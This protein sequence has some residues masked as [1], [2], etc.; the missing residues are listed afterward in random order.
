MRSPSVEFRTGAIVPD[1]SREE[2][3]PSMGRDAL[4]VHIGR[5]SATGDIARRKTYGN[6]RIP[7]NLRPPGTNRT[8]GRVMD[9]IGYRII[10]LNYNSQ[11]RHQM[12]CYTA[13]TKTYELVMEWS[14]LDLQIDDKIRMDYNKGLVIWFCPRT[15]PMVLNLERGIRTEAGGT[16]DV[17]PR[18][19]EYWVFDQLHRPPAFSPVILPNPTDATSTSNT[20]V[21]GYVAGTVPKPIDNVTETGVQVCFNYEYMDGV[22]SRYSEPSVMFWNN[23]VYV[24]VPQSEFDDYMRI[25]TAANPYIVATKWY[26]REGNTQ[27]WNLFKRVLNTPSEWIAPVNYG[28]QIAGILLTDLS[29]LTPIGSVSAAAALGVDGS[30]RF[31]RTG[32]FFNNRILQGG[33]TLGYDVDL[34]GGEASFMILTETNMTVRNWRIFAPIFAQQHDFMFVYYDDRGRTIGTRTINSMSFRNLFFSG[35]S[36]DLFDVYVA[37]G[38]GSFAI[39]DLLWNQVVDYFNFLDPNVQA[40]SRRDINFPPTIEITP[41]ATDLSTQVASV[42][43]ATKSHRDYSFFIRTQIRPFFIYRDASGNFYVFLDN[44]GGEQV[45]RSSIKMSFYGIGFE[46]ASGEPINF[47]TEQNYYVKQVGR[48]FARATTGFNYQAS[49]AF[50]VEFKITDQLGNILISKQ[51]FTS[52]GNQYYN[53]GFWSGVDV[54]NQVPNLGQYLHQICDV[55]LYSKNKVKSSD[56]NIIPQITWTPVEWNAR[57]VKRYYGDCYGCGDDKTM[58]G[59][60][61]QV[62]GNRFNGLYTQIGQVSWQGFWASMNLNGIFNENWNSD[63]GSATAINDQPQLLLQSRTYQHGEQYLEGTKINNLF[64]FNVDNRKLVDGTIGNI[65]DIINQSISANLGENL[66]IHCEQGVE[67]VMIGKVQQTGTDGIGILA[68]STKVFGTTNT[69]NLPY[70][71]Q[72]I[73]QVIIT[74]KGV[75]YYI[76]PVNR[77]LVQVSRNG[78]DAVSEQKDFISHMDNVPDDAVIGFDPLRMEILVSG[79]GYG[80][81]YKIDDNGIYQGRRTYGINNQT[82]MFAFLSSPAGAKKTYAFFDGEL[83]E[84]D[85]NST[86]IN[87]ED[88]NSSL[89]VVCNPAVKTLKNYSAVRYYSTQGKVWGVKVTNP[90][91]R[92]AVMQPT[93]FVNRM[94]YSESAITR[95]VNSAGGSES[96]DI[97]NGAWAIVEIFDVD[98]NPKDLVSLEVGFNPGLAK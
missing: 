29:E 44:R 87:G 13:T 14:G 95:D 30:A 96:G 27:P 88:F 86:T 49:L 46:F 98:S 23:G 72:T 78:Q 66:Y 8:V 73:G 76:D 60:N 26:Y 12:W 6:V 15:C 51:S 67:G 75:S 47:S 91:G 54:D 19:Y 41:G 9:H 24:L 94:E 65:V 74:T 55:A 25:G 40:N 32:G 16:V 89:T 4:N 3:Q 93:D 42:G 45:E 62:Y 28:S 10:F 36:V 59:E 37:G 61:R 81:A 5:N 35:W 31:A 17:Y 53:A 70:G 80:L 56:W 34:P 39:K 63:I 48:L 83:Y 58:S 84:F 97:I 82:E 38:L 52:T 11:G 69:Q 77:V 22:E 33:L 90:N 64:A 50:D 68:V 85:P 20:T 92:Q 2:M 7:N 79:K 1:L 57:V 18:P 71:P 21:V 43:L